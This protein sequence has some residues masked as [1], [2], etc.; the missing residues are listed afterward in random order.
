MEIEDL[1]E[2]LN[3]DLKEFDVE[4]NLENNLETFT[5]KQPNQV[6]LELY[7]TAREKAKQAKKNAIIAYLEAKNIKTK[8]RNYQNEKEIA[9]EQAKNNLQSNNI[10]NKISLEEYLKQINTGRVIL[11]RLNLFFYIIIFLNS[12]F[13]SEQILLWH[14]DLSL[15]N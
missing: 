12:R 14:P 13:R 2:D 9:K 3:E 11:F 6:Y 4:I 8:Q 7:K 15:Y 5:L 10:S 1:N